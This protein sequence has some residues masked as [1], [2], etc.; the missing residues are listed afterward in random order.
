VNG[1]LKTV[2]I[3]TAGVFGSWGIGWAP[4][5]FPGVKKVLV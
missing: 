4:P 5:K 2:V 3:G 1:V